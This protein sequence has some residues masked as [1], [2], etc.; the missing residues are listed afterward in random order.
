M[1]T[2]EDAEAI[3]NIAAMLVDTLVNNPH[4]KG[5]LHLAAALGVTLA[6]LATN[7]NEKN[8]LVFAFGLDTA[9]SIYEKQREKSQ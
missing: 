8:D 4:N 2:E 9:V 1:M 3:Q 6:A 7:A 5:A